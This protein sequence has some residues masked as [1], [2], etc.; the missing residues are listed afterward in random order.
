M[1]ASLMLLAAGCET[2]GGGDWG[3]RVGAMT[4]DDAIKELGP[5]ENRA[6][7]SDGTMVAQWQTARSRIYGTGMRGGWGWG[8]GWGGGT[9][10]TSTPDTYLQLTFGP[11]GRLASWRRIYK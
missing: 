2:Y 10:I 9:D 11:D 3:K 5:P 6:T 8:W 1:A 4:L 7:T